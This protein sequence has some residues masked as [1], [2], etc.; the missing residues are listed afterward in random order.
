MH[1]PEKLR[2]SPR[3]SH[4]ALKTASETGRYACFINAHSGSKHKDLTMKPS[5]KTAP[6]SGN[7][8]SFD[9]LSGLVPAQTSHRWFMANSRL[10]A[11]SRLARLH[12]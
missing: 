1:P 9:G 4:R 3:N 5:R 10:S 7:W 11:A 12:P 2:L 6:A 8:L